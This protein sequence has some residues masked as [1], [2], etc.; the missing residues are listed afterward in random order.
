MFGGE[1][2]K[3]KKKAG[4]KAKAGAA[5]AGDKSAGKDTTDASGAAKTP[6]G[7]EVRRRD[8]TPRVEEVEE[9]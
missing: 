6:N 4:K 2:D 9:D 1:Q 5:N 8:M 3:K 7:G